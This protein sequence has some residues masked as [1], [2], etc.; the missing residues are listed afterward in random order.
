MARRGEAPPIAANPLG[1]LAEQIAAARRIAEGKIGG[2]M[3]G[4]MPGEQYRYLVGRAAIENGLP[5]PGRRDV[6][7][8]RAVINRGDRRVQFSIRGVAEILSENGYDPAEEM[9]RIL[10]GDPDPDDP[11][12]RVYR[13]DAKT[14]LQ[15][16]NELLK[17]VH[18]QRKAVD[19]E[20][21]V[22]YSG[23][24]L[25]AQLGGAIGRLLSLGGAAADSLIAEAVRTVE[26]CEAAKAPPPAP[27]RSG[28]PIL[29]FD[30]W[31]MV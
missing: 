9:V 19:V 2:T 8:P 18:P 17:Y 24:E 27:A 30:P 29:D 3:V 16:S 6:E 22:Q 23:A 26:D 11:T 31:S 4:E 14:R 13:V 7:T 21:R 5:L 12:K 15:F 20:Q 10:A 28:P 25:D 1:T